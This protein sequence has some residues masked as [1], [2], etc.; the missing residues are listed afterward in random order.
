MSSNDLAHTLQHYIQLSEEKK[1]LREQ[2][3]EVE[4]YHREAAKNVLYL[5]DQMGKSGI[6][7]SDGRV[8]VSKSVR[9]R[10]T[11]NK[12]HIIDGLLQSGSVQDEQVA[13]DIANVIY[14]QRSVTEVYELQEK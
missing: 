14:E 8:F 13:K 10:G 2:L 1:K 4:Q 6:N 11:V 12:R 9:K 7:T 3:A 5:L